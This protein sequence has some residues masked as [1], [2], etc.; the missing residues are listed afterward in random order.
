VNTFQWT[1]AQ[2]DGAFQIQVTVRNNSTL[3]TAQLSANYQVTSRII[4]NQ[5]VVTPTSNA[6]VALYSIP[7]CAAG[8]FVQVKLWVPYQQ[9]DPPVPCKPGVSMNFYMAGMPPNTTNNFLYQIVTGSTVVQGPSSTFTS[10][11][12]PKSLILPKPT[13]VHPAGLNSSLSQSILLHGLILPLPELLATNF[14]GQV[15]WYYSGVAL[16]ARPTSDGTLLVT[17][18]GSSNT[19]RVLREIDLAGNILRETSSMRL[20]EQLNGLGVVGNITLNEHEAL[21]LPNGYTA[22]LANVERLFPAGTQGSSGPVD[23]LGTIVIVLDQNWQVNWYWNAFDHLNVS[24]AAVLGEVCNQQ[25][26]GCPP[27]TLASQANDWLHT[28]SIYYI[29]SDGN[30]LV[31]LRHQD[32][33]VKIDYQNGGG[34]GNVL[35][36]LGLGG[37]FT[38]SSSDP[39]PWFSH[40]HDASYDLNGTAVMSLYDNG[41]TRRVQNPALTE[42]SRGQVLTIDEVNRSVSLALNTDLGVYSAAFGSAQRLQNGN[43][44]FFSGWVSSSSGAFIQDAEITSKGAVAFELQAQ[45]AEAYRS[46]RIDSFRRP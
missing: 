24:R 44:H 21:R 26:I 15:V 35:W 34:T 2:N 42:N 18:G 36:R 30:L 8:S 29:P 22:I 23:I 40:Q 45:P 9:F 4:S 32:W 27:L 38:I 19:G 43:H 16:L 5:P 17:T 28:N 7:P 46:F 10:G 3:A 39:H 33:V 6:L 13:V 25:Q 31:S 12:L 37:D 20:A 1:P 41:N 14:F 11:S